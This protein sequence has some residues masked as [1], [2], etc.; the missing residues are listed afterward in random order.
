MNK[1]YLMLVRMLKDNTEGE[2]NWVVEGIQLHIFQ[3]ESNT[4]A[5]LKL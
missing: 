5:S 4:S 3:G 2:R 1:D